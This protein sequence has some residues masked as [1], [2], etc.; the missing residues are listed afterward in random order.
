MSTYYDFYLGTKKD[1]KF[2]ALAPF[3]QKKEG[4]VS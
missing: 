3:V 1:G 4:G 2:E